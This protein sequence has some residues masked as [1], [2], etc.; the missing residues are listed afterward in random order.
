MTEVGSA[1]VIT[2]KKQISLL[3]E[4]CLDE[5]VEFSVK[6]QTF[7]DT[8]WEFEMKLKDVNGA[9]LLGMFL[10]ENRIEM[11]GIDP[12]R[13]KRQIKKGDEK[14]ETV[15]KTSSSQKEENAK[16]DKAMPIESPDSPTLI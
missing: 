8:D 4:F 9:I 7:P 13:Y 14:V 11:D 3:V 6:Q 15:T 10:R 12:Q 1:T 5:S 16:Q 2:K